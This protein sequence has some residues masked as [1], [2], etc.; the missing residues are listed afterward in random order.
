MSRGLRYVTRHC[1]AAAPWCA[2]RS[3]VMRGASLTAPTGGLAD[4]PWPVER[5][6]AKDDNPDAM[7]RSE[8]ATLK[9]ATSPIGHGHTTE[10]A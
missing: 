2:S 3:R 7:R 10:A 4:S 5:S 1:R 8:L 9:Y 6:M